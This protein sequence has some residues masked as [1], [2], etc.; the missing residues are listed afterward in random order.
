M[1][2]T[3]DPYVAQLAQGVTNA[4]GLD[5][6]VVLAQWLAEEFISSANWPGYNPAGITPGNSVVDR[7]GTGA[8]TSGGFIIFPSPA[9]GAE[10]YATLYKTDPSYPGVRAAIQTGSPLA[11]LNAIIQS[12]WDTGHYGGDGHRLYAAY[13]AVTGTKY[14]VP[15]GLTFDLST[16]YALD[17]TSTDNQ[18]S[19]PATNYSVLANSQRTGNILYGRRYRILVSN[20]SGIALDVS[21]LHCTFDIQYVVNQQP[22]F[23]TV[24]IYNLN[25]ATENFLLNYGDKI[26]VEAGYEGSQYGV[27]FEG[28]VVEPIRDKPDNVTYRLTINAL[29]SNLQLNQAFA[30]FTVAR[31]QSARSLVQNLASNASVPS[32]IGEISPSLSTAKLPRGKVVFGL[33]R[34]FLR[35]IAQGNNAA[36]SMHDGRINLIHASDP[37]KGEIIDLTPQSGL[38]GQPVQNELGVSFKCLLNPAMKINTLVHID[39]SLV[40][41]QTYQ[42]GSV[43]RPLDAAG[44]YRVVG[45]EFIGDTRGDDW[46]CS[47]TTVSQA[48]GIPGMISTTTANPW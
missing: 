21:D 14:N 20:S 11:Q 17:N 15:S 4:I 24:V 39:N 47:C 3:I 36:Y 48:G 27:I 18:V 30:N 38:I 28:D 10:G 22:P 6:N 23:S 43:P 45:V 35:Q 25:P 42:I 12:P 41:A 19:F 9:A 32:P 44:I 46:Y 33:T 40:Q 1:G 26:V 29:T 16:T 31:G 5:R 37:P 34:D 7:L 8:L 13:T 2:V